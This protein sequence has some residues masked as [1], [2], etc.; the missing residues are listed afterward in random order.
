MPEILD[1]M[2]ILLC[3]AKTSLFFASNILKAGFILRG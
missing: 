1:S 3:Q 2:R